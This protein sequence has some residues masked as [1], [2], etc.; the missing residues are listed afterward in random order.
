ML[1]LRPRRGGSGPA[2]P[3][4]GSGKIRAETWRISPEEAW[5]RGLTCDLGVGV[6]EMAADDDLIHLCPVEV[7][8]GFGELAEEVVDVTLGA[9]IRVLEVGGEL[10]GGV[11]AGMR[12]DGNLRCNI[13]EWM[14]ALPLVGAERRRSAGRSLT[15]ALVAS[16]LFGRKRRG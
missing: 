10:N 13:G 14:N 3:S 1:R 6:G 8:A 5:P 16:H 9:L 4:L 15:G 2:T 7:T 11:S 12:S